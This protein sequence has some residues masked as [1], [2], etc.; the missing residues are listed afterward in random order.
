MSAVKPNQQ[1][2]STKSLVIVGG[3]I[4]AIAISLFAYLMWYTTGEEVVESVKVVAVTGQGCVV[5]TFDGHA[6]TIE[7][8]NAKPGDIISAPIDQK[9]KERALSMNPTS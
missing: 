5:E 7:Q 3:I 1:T 9:I 8:C 6:F 2:S 4:A